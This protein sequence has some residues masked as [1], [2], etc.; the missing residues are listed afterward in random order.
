[1][2]LAYTSP[3]LIYVSHRAD[4]IECETGGAQYIIRRVHFEF[5]SNVTL[6]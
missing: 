2:R 3:S 5:L 4:A 1:M 6:C